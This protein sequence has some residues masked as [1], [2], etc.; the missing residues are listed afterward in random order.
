MSRGQHVGGVQQE[1]PEEG[2][3]DLRLDDREQGLQLQR[4]AGEA[5]ADEEELLGGRL[6]QTHEAPIKGGGEAEDVAGV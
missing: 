2:R 6:K 1:V 5:A 3:A 4:Q